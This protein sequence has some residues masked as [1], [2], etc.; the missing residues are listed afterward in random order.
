M[1]GDRDVDRWPNVQA[2]EGRTTYV[3]LDEPFIGGLARACG[4]PAAERTADRLAIYVPAGRGRPSPPSR[5]A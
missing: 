2:A 1:S 3:A 4:T 5:S